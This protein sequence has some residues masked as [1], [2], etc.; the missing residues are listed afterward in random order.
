M[1]TSGSLEKRLTE[2]LE[3]YPLDE[4]EEIINTLSFMGLMEEVPEPEDE[5]EAVGEIVPVLL[6]LEEE[7]RVGELKESLPELVSLIEKDE[8]ESSPSEGEEEE[9]EEEEEEETTKEAIPNVSQV[10]Y[11]T[12]TTQVPYKT[13]TT[14]VPYKTST[15]QVPYKT[16]TTQVPYKT[17]TTQVPYKTSPVKKPAPAVSPYR[18]SPVIPAKKPAPAVSPYR[19]SPVIPAKK[20]PV[21]PYKASS[22]KKPVASPYKRPAKATQPVEVSPAVEYL[23]QY[24]IDEIRQIA[25]SLAAEVRVPY[26]PGRSKVSAAEFIISLLPSINLTEA[27]DISPVLA[28]VKEMEGGDDYEEEEEVEE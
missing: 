4:L 5:S 10:P 1:S 22:S 2:S 8:S 3:Q 25:R 16:S 7:G 11:K 13:S 24:S 20:P 14:Q 28:Q 6:E 27:E 18:A 12:S 17:S 19:A 26:K 23:I 15:T 9:G 21:S